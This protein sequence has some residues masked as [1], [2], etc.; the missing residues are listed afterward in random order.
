M[1]LLIN[2]SFDP[3]PNHLI[4]GAIVVLALCLRLPYIESRSLHVDEAFSFAMASGHALERKDMSPDPTDY[5]DRHSAVFSELYASYI[6]VSPNFTDLFSAV[7]K[8]DGSPPLYYMALRIW[9]ELFGTSVFAA[10]GLSLIFNLLALFIIYL[11]GSNFSRWGG[12]VATL[13]LAISPIQVHYPSEIR[14]YGLLVLLVLLSYLFTYLLTTQSIGEKGWIYWTLVNILG[15][16]THYIFVSVFISINLYILIVLVREKSVSFAAWAVS[17]A[18]CVILFLP[19]VPF[20]FKQFSPNIP[21]RS[22]LSSTD[23]FDILFLKFF[24]SIGDLSWGAR[25]N[26]F[27]AGFTWLLFGLGIYAL[28]IRKEWKIATFLT[29]TFLVPIFF[30][31]SLDCI[32]ATEQSVH[33]R[34]FIHA[35]PALYLASGVAIGT[36]PKYFKSG[37]IFVVMIYSCYHSAGMVKWKKYDREPFNLASDYIAGKANGKEI[38]LV[39]SIPSGVISFSHYS[40]PTARIGA[41]TQ[42]MKKEESEKRL[43]KLLTG[44]RDDVWL[45]I[46]HTAITPKFKAVEEDIKTWLKQYFLFKERVLVGSIELNHYLAKKN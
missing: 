34:Y 40:T 24:F 9:M 7:S 42:N 37:L 44:H 38:I 18:M 27:L 14:M 15:L 30:I 46:A 16:Y 23:S 26:L 28:W 19:W 21:F 22:W 35:T 39:R 3:F 32:R 2:K 17:C 1:K 36:F 11:L 12:I 43:K 33:I 8:T 5:Y 25:G 45:V 10:R 31:L 6:K 20:I 29:L 41:L 4:F 13:F